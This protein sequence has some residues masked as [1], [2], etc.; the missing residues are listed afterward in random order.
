MLKG[1]ERKKGRKNIGRGNGL[2]YSKFDEK[3]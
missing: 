1:E 3:Y 2:K